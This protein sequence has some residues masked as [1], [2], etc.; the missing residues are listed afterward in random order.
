MRVILAWRDKWPSTGNENI[1]FML[2]IA[3]LHSILAIV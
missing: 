3:Q 2:F 1:N